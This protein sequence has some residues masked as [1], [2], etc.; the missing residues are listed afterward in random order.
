VGLPDERGRRQILEV[1]ARSLLSNGFLRRE[2]WRG[3]SMAQAKVGPGAA[4]TSTATGSA[5]TDL[6]STENDVED[7]EAEGEAARLAR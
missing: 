1:H 5:A 3:A 4:A 2:T 6:S 7:E